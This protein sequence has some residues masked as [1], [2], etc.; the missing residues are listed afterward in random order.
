[1]VG[2]RL[3]AGAEVEQRA[4]LAHG[5]ATT[6]QSRNP[7]DRGEQIKIRA[8][9]APSQVD[10]PAARCVLTAFQVAM[11]RSRD[12]AQLKQNKETEAVRV[13]W[14]QPILVVRQAAITLDVAFHLLDTVGVVLAGIDD[15]CGRGIG[16]HKR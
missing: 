1:M 2:R 15:R 8:H 4:D 16:G 13:L 10:V 5:E 11:I 7:V 14:L 12:K 3:E 6:D 9:V